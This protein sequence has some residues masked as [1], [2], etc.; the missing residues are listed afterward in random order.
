MLIYLFSSVITCM[1][2]SQRITTELELN[3]IAVTQ[4]LEPSEFETT[5]QLLVV[6]GSHCLFCLSLSLSVLR[7]N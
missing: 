3:I 5:I 4:S 1:E 2:A 7:P 6:K